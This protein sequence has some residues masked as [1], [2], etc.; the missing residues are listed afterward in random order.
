MR[1]C[2]R[3]KPE[4]YLN[5]PT[6]GCARSPCVTGPVGWRQPSTK[7][8]GQASA[9]HWTRPSSRG[10]WLWRADR[11][12]RD[13]HAGPCACWRPKPNDERS[14]PALA[15]KPFA[16]LSK[17]TTSSR[18]GKKMWCVAEVDEAYW[19]RM[20]DVLEIYERPYNPQEPV[21]C[22]DEKPVVLHRD[23]RPASAAEPA[24]PAKRDYEY[25]RCGTANVFCAV[26]PLAGRH[27]TWPTPNRSGKQF[28]LILRRL[29]NAYP[30]ARTIHLVLDNLST[31]SR[32]VGDYRKALEIYVN[33]F[34]PK[35]VS[36]MP[37]FPYNQL[38]AIG[39]AYCLIELGR[40]EEAINALNCLAA[41]KEK[42]AEYFSNLSLAQMRRSDH[43]AAANVAIKGCSFALIIQIW[44]EIC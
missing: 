42:P 5:S 38:V 36:A 7:G 12:R 14:C 29:A 13:K 40:D 37:D 3:H 44:S 6:R 9:R 30:N 4:R 33:L 43:R 25:E 22:L 15:G 26:E 35:V 32:S 1:G 23:L 20:D 21:V 17:T 10:S 16:S 27:F 34:V 24:Q 19:E 8:P 39:Y 2:P 41:G 31:H 11:R 18:G 28:A